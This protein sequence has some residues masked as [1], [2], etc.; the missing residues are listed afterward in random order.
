MALHDEQQHYICILLLMIKKMVPTDKETSS[1]H[2]AW[3]HGQNVHLISSE[4]YMTVSYF[5]FAR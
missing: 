5:F 4:F 1:M 3:S 2:D